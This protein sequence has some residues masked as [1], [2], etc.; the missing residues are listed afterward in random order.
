MTIHFT[1]SLLIIE[2]SDEDFMAFMRITKKLSLTYP[3]FRCTSA[4]EALDSLRGTSHDDA[5]TE[6]L[7]PSIILL[8][9][10]LPGMDGRELLQI[11]EQDETLKKIPVVVFTTSSNP[12]DVD[13]CYQR[14][15]KSYIV[16]P[17]N[18]EQLKNTVKTFWD[19]WFDV[20]IL[21][22]AAESYFRL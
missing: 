11:L 14:G 16:K 7:R 1:P 19:Y 9:L 3:V 20:V 4:D 6:T 18:V 13:F 8:D 17:I 10:N 2:D 5:P 22:S 15:V 21:P 12:K